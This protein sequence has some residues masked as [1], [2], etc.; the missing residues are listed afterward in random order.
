[1]VS[2]ILDKVLRLFERVPKISNSV[3]HILNMVSQSLKR[4]PK[5]LYKVPRFFYGSPQILNSVHHLPIQ[6][7]HHLSKL[8]I[9][10][11]D[12]EIWRNNVRT[13]VGLSTFSASC[14]L[15]WMFSSCFMFTNRYR[16][17][18][19]VAPEMSQTLIN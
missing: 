8:A 17:L 15:L 1:M 4:L 11:T 7:L 6:K 9:Q 16:P 2:Q 14:S 5:I 12:K 18:Y 13:L 19:I 10:F 3:S